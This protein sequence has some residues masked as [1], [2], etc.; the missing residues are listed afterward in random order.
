M[1]IKVLKNSGTARD[2]S[3]LKKAAK[4][5][6]ERLLSP[7]QAANISLNISITNLNGRFGEAVIN[8]PVLF[9]VRLYR[10]ACLPMMLVTLAHELVHVSQVV[11]G[12]LK[13]SQ[14]NDLTEW[15]W[16]GKSYGTDP[17]ENWAGKLPWEVEASKR[18]VSLAFD[19]LQEHVTLL[20]G[21]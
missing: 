7:S 16:K 9:K 18:E 10:D 13:V 3:L 15:F 1:R 17:Y 21:G 14:I 5:M 4:Y 20:N 12:N 2:V 11:N 6:I 8:D 19:F